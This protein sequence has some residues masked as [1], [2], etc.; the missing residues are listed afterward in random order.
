MG[1]DGENGERQHRM[2]DLEALMWGLEADPHLS[3]TFANL[4]FMDRSPDPERLRNRLWYATREVPR[5]RR[6]V[7]PG[8]GPMT[9]R[10][11]EDPAFDLD[12]HLKRVRLPK[13][14]TEADVRT[15][16]TELVR[17]PFDPERPLWE[18]TVFDGLPGGRSAMVQKMHH[19]ITDGKGGIRLSVAFVDLEREPAEAPGTTPPPPAGAS[20]SDAAS[21]PGPV[22]VIG[23]A[24]ADAA[25]RNVDGARRLVEG[26]ADLA[27]DPLHLGAVLAGLPAETAAAAQSVVRQLGVTDSMRSPLWR[28][29]SLDRALE[30][31]QV[32]FAAVKELSSAL[33]VSVNDVFVAAAAGGAGRYHRARGVDVDE[34]R[35][36]MPISTRTDRAAAG[37]AFAITRTLVSVEADPRRRLAAVHDRLAVTKSEKLAVGDGLARLGRLVPRPAMALVARQ[38]AMTVDFTT[39]NVRA[40]PFDLYLA[41]ALMEANYPLGPIAGTAWNLTTM[42]YRGHLDLGLHVDTGAVEEPAALAADIRDAFA[43]LLEL[44]PGK[45]SRRRPAR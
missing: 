7:A 10:W 43:E 14:A 9:P 22:E 31:F 18:F 17:E 45:A 12:R 44:T 40:A 42:S 30:V 8:L 28:E 26:A 1:R 21:R 19:S 29:R 33:G 34:L 16:A 27:R 36:A 39:S 13:G 4:T 11:E 32:P 37:N 41:G 2:S 23:E 3:S 15:L 6:R 5:L 24:L 38:Q 25:R 35:M 20:G